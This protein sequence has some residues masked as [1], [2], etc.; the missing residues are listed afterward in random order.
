MSVS[1][2]LSSLSA[3]ST[4]V[5]L[6]FTSNAFRSLPL[7]IPFV[8]ASCCFNCGKTLSCKVLISL[9]L[10]CTFII[11]FLIWQNSAISM[12]SVGLGGISF[13]RIRFCRKS[14]AFATIPRNRL[15]SQPLLL[16]DW[17]AFS[18]ISV[19][20]TSKIFASEIPDNNAISAVLFHSCLAVLSA[21]I[22]AALGLFLPI[23]FV[24][25]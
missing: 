12:S 15:G 2:I 4:S 11:R 13:S 21:S 24:G 9:A 18:C 3:I 7:K 8:L 1:G 6:I 14:F 20:L 17:L 5:S 25:R 23:F 22:S 19:C 10:S 16:M